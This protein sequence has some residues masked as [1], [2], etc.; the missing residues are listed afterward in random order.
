MNPIAVALL[1]FVASQPEIAPAPKLV[2]DA[3]PSYMLNGVDGK[4]LD[5]GYKINGN[6]ATREQVYAAFAASI[7]DVSTKRRITVIGDVEERKAALKEIGTPAWALVNAYPRDHW[8]TKQCGFVATGKPTIYVTESTGEVIHRQDNTD[9]LKV[10]MHKADPNYNAAT[11]PDLRKAPLVVPPLLAPVVPGPVTPD[12][13]PAEVQ[14]LLPVIPGMPSWYNLLAFALGIA[15]P[16]VAR[17]RSNRNKESADR[18]IL[19][20]TLLKER[21]ASNPPQGGSGTAAPKL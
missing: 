16:L 19:I 15:G 9:G 13:K 5:G 21:A 3:L 1:V 11:D 18:E 20:A 17:W 8:Y 10:A 12:G 4:K 7:P 6:D 14:P 2:G